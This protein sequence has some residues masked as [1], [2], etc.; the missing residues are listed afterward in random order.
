LALIAGVAVVLGLVAVV[1]FSQP[2]KSGVLEGIEAQAVGER[3]HVDGEF[4]ED[5]DVPA[6]GAYNEVWQNCGFYVEEIESD[7]AVHSLEHGGRILRDW[8][9]TVL[10]QV[11]TDFPQ[12]E[13]RRRQAHRLAWS[14]ASTEDRIRK[15]ESG[16]P[17]PLA[18]WTHLC[19]PWCRLLHD[20]RPERRR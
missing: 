13:V 15:T 6:G 20:L 5:G 18:A 2:E 4:H 17:Y 14:A 16:F 8:P 7:H 11:S 10:A 3:A 12:R 1:M 19:H 9:S